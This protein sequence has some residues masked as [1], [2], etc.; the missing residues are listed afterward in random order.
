MA[1]LSDNY[2]AKRQDGQIVEYK[3]ANTENIYKGALC[4]LD[5]SDGGYLEAA[6]DDAAGNVFA[7]IAV[8]KSLSADVTTDSDGARSVRLYRSGV[9]TL[10][11]S[12]A[13]QTWV[14][15]EIYVVD[16]GTV[17]QTT[18]HAPYVGVCVEYISAT[19]IR[20]D[21]G[22]GIAANTTTS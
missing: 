21:I 10:V 4:M 11:T 5:E 7:G 9:F 2:E 12:G 13:D 14:G 6:T 8:E 1:I 22:P 3:I 16:S 15:T 18:T 20:V 17:S 19:S